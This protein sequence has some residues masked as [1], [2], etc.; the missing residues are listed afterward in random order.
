VAS[1][2]GVK[3]LSLVVER[4]NSPYFEL[5]REYFEGWSVQRAGTSSLDMSEFESATVLMCDEFP[6]TWLK[7]N[8]WTLPNVQPIIVGT[9]GREKHPRNWIR[10]NRVV[11]H[12]EVGGGS[13]SIA[14]LRVYRR[15]PKSGKTL[16]GL[17][18]V[19]RKPGQDLRSVLKMVVSGVKVKSPVSVPKET[20][21]EAVYLAPGVVASWGLYDIAKQPRVRTVYGGDYWVTRKLTAMEWATV[22]DLPEKLSKSVAKDELR[23]FVKDCRVPLKCYQAT[24]EMIERSGET[25]RVLKTTVKRKHEGEDGSSERLSKEQDQSA[26]RPKVEVKDLKS[27]ELEVEFEPAS[28]RYPV[29]KIVEMEELA[30]ESWEGN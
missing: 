26:K 14:S 17:N 2:L 6:G 23:N 18:A 24:L 20:G 21:S 29:S 12:Q 10:E 22:Y 27:E 15:K 1:K 3:V 7:R 11:W 9:I 16:G 8:M 4:F 13:N 19:A 28:M 5:A 25:S 30:E